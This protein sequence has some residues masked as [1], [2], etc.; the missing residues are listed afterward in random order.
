MAT[1]TP[2]GGGGGGGGSPSSVRTFVPPEFYRTPFFPYASLP[3]QLQDALSLAGRGA[4]G[5]TNM[6]NPMFQSILNSQ[7]N[8]GGGL[9]GKSAYARGTPASGGAMTYPMPASGIP[10][11]GQYTPGQQMTRP[12]APVAPGTP[13]RGGGLLQP[14]IGSGPNPF[15]QPGAR[16][17]GGAPPPTGGRSTPTGGTPGVSAGGAP[18]PYQPGQQFDPGTGNTSVASMLSYFNSLPQEQRG[19]YINAIDQYSLGKGGAANLGAALQQALRGQMGQQQ[20]DNWYASN[21]TN[22]QGSGVGREGL[23]SWLLSALGG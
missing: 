21:V 17:G 8:L 10:G 22:K 12:G 20:F 7:P 13:P 6:A 15:Q 11:P 5:F 2:T 3:A 4:G 18:L 23:P 19:N 1:D 14:P 9:L 16:G